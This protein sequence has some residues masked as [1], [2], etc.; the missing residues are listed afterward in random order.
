MDSECKI[1]SVMEPGGIIA[2]N[3]VQK[4]TQQCVS[5]FY[6]SKLGQAVQFG[7]QRQG[8]NLP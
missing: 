6:T 5:N 1:A 8:S 2:T 7:S 4:K 3:T